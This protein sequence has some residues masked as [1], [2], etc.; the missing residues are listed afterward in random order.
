MR[1]IYQGSEKITSSHLC[2]RKHI[3]Q[4]ITLTFTSFFPSF[5]FFFSSFF[6]HLPVPLQPLSPSLFLY[7][8]ERKKKMWDYFANEMSL[9]K[10]SVF[11]RSHFACLIGFFVR[12]VI[13]PL[14]E[15]SQLLWIINTI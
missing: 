13:L 12:V 6:L 3:F 9:A 5:F 11:H 15:G 7:N 14:F 4:D 1:P 2:S 10:R 8:S